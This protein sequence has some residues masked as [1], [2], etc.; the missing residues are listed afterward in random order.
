MFAAKLF[1]HHTV[2]LN[3]IKYQLALDIGNITVLQRLRN[4]AVDVLTFDEA[5]T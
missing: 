4:M 5:K 3:L 1:F 2:F